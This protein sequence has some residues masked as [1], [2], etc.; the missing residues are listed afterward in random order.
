M[1]TQD[2]IQKIIEAQ[3]DVFPT[4]TEFEVFKEEMKKD[5]S[6]LQISVDAYAQKAD[7]SL[8]A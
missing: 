6:D 8:K 5:F 3:K 1:L 2:D 7:I 4:K